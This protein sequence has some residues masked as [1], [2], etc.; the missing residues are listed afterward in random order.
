MISYKVCSHLYDN[1]ESEISVAKFLGFLHEVL[2]VWPRREA[3]TN[4]EHVERD[5]LCFIEV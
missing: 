1:A 2:D 3:W 4:P 5:W